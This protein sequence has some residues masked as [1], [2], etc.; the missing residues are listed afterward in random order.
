MEIRQ[1]PVPHYSE[2]LVSAWSNAHS[3]ECE[4]FRAVPRIRMIQTYWL[5]NDAVTALVPPLK[6]GEG[7]RCVLVAP[8]GR[9]WTYRLGPWP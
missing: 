9:G 6:R 8:H 2:R 1:E 3:T 5:P 7:R 4:R